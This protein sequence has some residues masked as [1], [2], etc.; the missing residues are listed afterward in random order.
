MTVAADR[1]CSDQE[2]LVEDIIPGIH[3]NGFGQIGDGRSFAF[4]TQRNQLVVEIYRPRLAGPVPQSEDVVAVATRGLTD[5]DV[6]DER[7]LIAAV[8]DAIANAEP[9][10]RAG[11]KP[12]H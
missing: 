6:T 11:S 5:I 9:V 3:A 12:L 2:F 4:H 7:S 8:R 10:S 1:E